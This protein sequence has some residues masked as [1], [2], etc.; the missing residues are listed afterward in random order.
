MDDIVMTFNPASFLLGIGQVVA[1]MGNL[2]KKTEESAKNLTKNTESVFQNF[3][4]NVGQSN[5][6]V[7]NQIEENKT[8]IVNF[9]DNAS[10]IVSAITKRVMMLGVAWQAAKKAMQFIPEI[11]RTFQIAGDIIGRNLLWPLRRELMPILQKFLNWVRDHRAM[12][13]RWGTVLVNIFRTIKN[14]VVGFIDLLSN[15]WRRL[16]AGIER[17]FGRTIGRMTDLAN[18]LIFKISVVAQFI[19]ITLEP[20]FKFIVDQFLKLVEYAKAFGEGF[21]AVIGD[22]MEPLTDIGN[23]VARLAKYLFSAGKGGSFLIKTFRILGAVLGGAVRIALEGVAQ[24][25]DSLASSI[26][27]VSSM[28]G[29]LKAKIDGNAKEAAKIRREQSLMFKEFEERSAKRAARVKQTFGRAFDVV[30]HEITRKPEKG[31]VAPRG[32]KGE[33][34]KT[35]IKTREVVEKKEGTKTINNNVNIAPMTLNVTEGNAKKTAE[36]FSNTIRTKLQTE[37]MLKGDKP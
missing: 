31:V 10:N 1:A 34:I 8:S 2:D 26:S 32:A 23:S 33:A 3:E 15:M 4:N 16:S 29:L 18:M 27:G 21:T 12:F 17:I 9:K 22:L 25:I 36:D 24:L 5:K 14:I 30:K 19:L 7:K 13:V 37:M 35:V 28:I 11:G 20:V 6:K